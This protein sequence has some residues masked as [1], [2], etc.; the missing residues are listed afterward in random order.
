M[1]ISAPWII[2]IVIAAIVLCTGRYV[3]KT[4]LGT[5]TKAAKLEKDNESAERWY[6]LQDKYQTH[7]PD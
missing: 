6:K 3:Y 2:G 5:D 7:N 4:Q 1:K